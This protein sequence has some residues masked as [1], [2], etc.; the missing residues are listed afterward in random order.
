MKLIKT[1]RLF[2][3]LS[4]VAACFAAAP[5]AEPAAREPE[6]TTAPAAGKVDPKAQAVLDRYVEATGGKANHD[7][8]K[9]RLVK[10]KL[11]IV[12]ANL[13]GSVVTKQMSPNKMLTLTE[14]AGIGTIEQ[15][16]DGTVG[17]MK[18]PMQGNQL[19]E[20]K[21]LEQVKAQAESENSDGDPAKQYK[22]V[23][24]A[25][26]ETVDGVPMDKLELENATGKSTQ[27]YAKDTGLL[28]RSKSTVTTQM[29]ETEMTMKFSDYVEA[30]GVKYPKTVETLAGPQTIK[31]TIE[32]VQL[33]PDSV[34]A[35]TFKIPDDI[36]ALLPADKGPD[37]K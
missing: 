26:E 12:G 23:A 2:A 15:G 33:N 8:V 22:S 19:L 20:G 36:R 4:L 35:D 37:K 7:K 14:I 17:W 9:S 21:Q 25:G 1:A 13:A 18:N 6:P 30:G 27:Y 31:V 29:G 24:Y 34:T 32:D 10:A 28:V 11:E 5:R 3:S 16:F